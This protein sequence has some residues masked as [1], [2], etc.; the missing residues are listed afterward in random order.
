VRHAAGVEPGHLD[1]RYHINPATGLPNKCLDGDTCKFGGASFHYPSKHDAEVAWQARELERGII[2]Y[3]NVM[4]A[5]ERQEE[6]AALS[7]LADNAKGFSKK[8]SWGVVRSVLV[9]NISKYVV[10]FLG[11]FMAYAVASGKWL[12]DDWIRRLLP[13]TASIVLVALVA[14]FTLKFAKGGRKAA[15]AVK[16]RRIKR[17]IRKA[18]ASRNLPGEATDH[19]RT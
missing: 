3:R 17:H 11:V 19:R 5:K 15:K 13:T 14:W 12:S 7:R 16:K 2:A 8:L 6:E 1:E 4:Q 18:A 10:N 9:R